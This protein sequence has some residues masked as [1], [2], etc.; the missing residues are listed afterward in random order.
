LVEPQPA[1]AMTANSA[2]TTRKTD[3]LREAGFKGAAEW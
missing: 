2:I 1:I 3:P